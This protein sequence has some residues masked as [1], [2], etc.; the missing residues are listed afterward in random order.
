MEDTS[1]RFQEV[2]Y[3]FLNF[4]AFA[5]FVVALLWLQ[6]N[7]GTAKGFKAF[8]AQKFIKLCGGAAAKDADAS[9]FA[10]LCKTWQSYLQL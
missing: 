10:S 5:S 2:M 8:W 7:Q 9:N 4:V 6:D 3:L 1:S